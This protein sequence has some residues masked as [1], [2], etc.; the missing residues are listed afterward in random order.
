MQ[1]AAQARALTGAVQVG[2]PSG[3]KVCVCESSSALAPIGCCMEAVI[4]NCRGPR[5]KQVEAE[6]KVGQ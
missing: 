1:G 5:G 3:S 6:E 2:T 4:I